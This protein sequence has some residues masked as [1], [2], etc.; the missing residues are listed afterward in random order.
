MVENLRPLPTTEN[1]SSGLLGRIVATA[2]RSALSADYGLNAAAEVSN[3]I[4]KASP[5]SG[6][7]IDQQ[8]NTKAG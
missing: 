6:Q 4:D 8:R 5:W 1:V 3:T 7:S 2:N